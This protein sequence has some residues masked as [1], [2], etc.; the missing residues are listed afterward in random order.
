MENNQLN[1][2]AKVGIIASATTTNSPFKTAFKST[3][4]FYAAQALLSLVTI[5]IF[6]SIVVI[7]AY[8]TLSK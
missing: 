5:G 1:K 2:A 7:V 6:A 8:F 3:M 4:G